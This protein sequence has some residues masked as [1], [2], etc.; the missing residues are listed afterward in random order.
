MENTIVS[1][2]NATSAETYLN[3]GMVLYNDG[4][5]LSA[6]SDFDEAIHL[7]SEYASAYYN[8][9]LAK[10]IL[11]RAAEAKQD[12]LTALSFVENEGDEGLKAKILSKLQK[13]K[14]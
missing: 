8:R 5:Y 12:F 11:G 6:I 1:S 3:K 10:N 13:G 9:G 7:K 4:N 2:E 14:E